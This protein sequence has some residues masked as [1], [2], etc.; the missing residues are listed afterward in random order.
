[1]AGTYTKLLYHVVFSTKGRRQLL[2]A[3]IE[4]DL[5]AYVGG[6]IRNHEGGL[7]AAGGMPGHIHLLL[8]LKPRFALSDIIRDIK[9]NFSAWLNEQIRLPYKFGWQ[10][11][12]AAFTVSQSQVTRVTRYIQGQKRHHK[13]ADFKD[14]LRELLR[15]HNLEFDERYLWR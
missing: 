11:G 1:M 3:A 8:T 13:R 9:A 10:D 6:V 7:L 12:F 15:K 14:E 2:T 5:Y 4:E